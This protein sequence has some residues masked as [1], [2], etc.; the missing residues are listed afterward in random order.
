MLYGGY[1][2]DRMQPKVQMA[3]G[4]VCYVLPI[5]LMSMTTNYWLF[6]FLYTFVNA[7]GFGLLY[8][9]PVRNAWLY[10]P[11]KKGTVSGLIM[12]NYSVGAI[13]WKF[14]SL[15]LANPSNIPPTLE[16]QRGESVEI[17]F[18]AES[19]VVE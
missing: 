4:G 17:L 14:I 2:L 1:L 7:A 12:M 9:L 10:Y 6:F 16:I 8:M 11:N 5:F 18:A 15:G 13:A 19:E 3:L